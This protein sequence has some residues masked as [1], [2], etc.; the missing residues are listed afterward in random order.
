MEL[1]DVVCYF[2]TINNLVKVEGN[3]EGAYGVGG[4]EDEPK[5]KKMKMKMKMK[6]NLRDWLLVSISGAACSVGGAG[7]WTGQDQDQFGKSEL[8]A[9]CHGQAGPGYKIDFAKKVNES[10]LADLDW[11][12]P[13]YS[14]SKIDIS[15]IY[16]ANKVDE[17]DF[18]NEANESEI[19]EV[20]N[21]KLRLTGWWLVQSKIDFVSKINFANK[22]NE[23]KG[24]RE[25]VLK[26]EWEVVKMEHADRYGD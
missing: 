15:N 14:R 17:I 11:A 12:N 22:V 23:V 3:L 26:V 21:S 13:G 18:A 2:S 5:K 9:G 1:V 19:S 8:V 25:A 24:S 7:W 6:I 20:E 4:H 16:F 10:W